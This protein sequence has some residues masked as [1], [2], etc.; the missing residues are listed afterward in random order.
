LCGTPL[1][2]ANNSKC[3]LAVNKSNNAL[4]WGQYPIYFLAISGYLATSY[5]IIYDFPDDGHIS[6]VNIL[7]VVVFPAPL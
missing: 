7:K 6:E 4:Y 2:S 1:I 3:S 5:P